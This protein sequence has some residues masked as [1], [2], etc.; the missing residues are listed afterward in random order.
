M[1]YIFFHNNILFPPIL[2]VFRV[3][4]M[5]EK[6]S[7]KRLNYLARRGPSGPENTGPR[8][9]KKKKKETVLDRSQIIFVRSKNR[10]LNCLKPFK[11]HL[12]KYI[13]AKCV[14]KYLV[15]KRGSPIGNNTIT[16]EGLF[17]KRNKAKSCAKLA[18]DGFSSI[19][20]ILRNIFYGP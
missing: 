17:R 8:V 19:F 16:P 3:S 12:S 14:G 15:E 11:S 5:R 4:G 18:I 7:K 10:L 20:F 6:T 13:Y 9:R 2:R 1:N